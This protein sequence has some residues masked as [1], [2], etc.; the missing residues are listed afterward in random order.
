MRQTM[1]EAGVHH[2][3]ICT[4]D[5]DVAVRFCRDGMGLELIGAPR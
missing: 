2:S 3:A 1:A 5:V 4:G